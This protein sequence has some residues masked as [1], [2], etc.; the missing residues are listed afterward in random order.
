MKAVHRA[1]RSSLMVGRD[2]LRWP[3]PKR[4]ARIIS[5]ALFN[6]S[7]ERPG[8]ARHAGDHVCD[9]RIAKTLGQNVER[10]G[11]MRVIHHI[12]QKQ[13]E[14]LLDADLSR[15]KPV[16]QVLDRCFPLLRVPFDDGLDNVFLAFEQ[17]VYLAY[18]HLGRGGQLGDRGLMKTLG[19][20]QV[21]RRVQYA[22]S[23]ILLMLQCNQNL[24]LGLFYS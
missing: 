7:P 17:A 13:F 2:R 6:A 4:Q 24:S 15:I 21:A 3:S 5:S 11:F 18:R 22:V 20:E 10:Q 16:L 19:G 14:R 1:V 12:Q 9:P 8:L 23:G